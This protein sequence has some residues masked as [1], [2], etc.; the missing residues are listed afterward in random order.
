M[1]DLRKT[2]DDAR[3][4]IG[5]LV[6][7]VTSVYGFISWLNSN[8]VTKLEAA[9]FAPQQTVEEVREDVAY[10]QLFIVNKMME[11]KQEQNQT[12]NVEYRSLHKRQF[13]L[14][15]KLELIDEDTEYMLPK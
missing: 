4:V 5:T 15:K 2:F 7:V 14:M 11:E 13:K 8:F 3:Y 6:L 1:A 10:N 9:T 12:D